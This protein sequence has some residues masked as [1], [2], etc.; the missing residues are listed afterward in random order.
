MLINKVNKVPDFKENQTVSIYS[1]IELADCGV[2]DDGIE[3]E[4]SNFK[5]LDEAAIATKVAPD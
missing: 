2:R 4:S 3:H 1:L 5:Q